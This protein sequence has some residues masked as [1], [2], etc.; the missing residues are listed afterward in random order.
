MLLDRAHIRL[1]QEEQQDGE[2][3]KFAANHLLMRAP[4]WLCIRPARACALIDAKLQMPSRGPP[5]KI[6]RQLCC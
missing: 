2:V 6:G 1:Q 3:V 4:D 5:T